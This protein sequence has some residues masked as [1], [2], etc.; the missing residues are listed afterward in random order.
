MSVLGKKL[1]LTTAN[2]IMNN[3]AVFSSILG[4]GI[5]YNIM[6]STDYGYK[7]VY[8]D[9]GICQFLFNSEK[10]WEVDPATIWF[11]VAEEL[12]I[13]EDVVRKFVD[14]CNKQTNEI[15]IANKLRELYTF[16]EDISLVDF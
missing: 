14:W 10:G 8:S 5:L 15:A 16:Y 4:N 2:N 11:Q 13:E 1:L 6:L 3:Q 7:P 9:D 12:K